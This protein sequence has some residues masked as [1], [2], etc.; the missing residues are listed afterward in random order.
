MRKIKMTAGRI[1]LLTGC[2]LVLLM[3]IGF[4]VTLWEQEKTMRSKQSDIRQLEAQLEEMR[5]T[6]AAMEADLEFSRTDAYI[7]RLAR[8]E[9]G[10]VKEGEI[11]FI[12]AE[13]MNE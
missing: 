11:K 1:V 9:L 7:E 4:G 8:E 3:L 12:A 6:A 10:Y 5:L 13:E 2:G